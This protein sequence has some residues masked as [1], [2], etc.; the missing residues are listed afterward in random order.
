M[1]DKEGNLSII[2]L[3]TLKYFPSSDTETE[4]LNLF[5]P[6]EDLYDNLDSPRIIRSSPRNSGKSCLIT[7]TPKSNSKLGNNDTNNLE[8]LFLEESALSTNEN[9]EKEESSDSENEYELENDSIDFEKEDTV[10]QILRPSIEDLVLQ[11]EQ[12]NIVCHGK[13][14]IVLIK[15]LGELTLIEDYTEIK[16]KIKDHPHE[17]M[18]WDTYRDIMSKLEVKLKNTE[19]NLKIQIEEIQ[20][21]KLKKIMSAQI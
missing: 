2:R 5:A 14:A 20:S 21:R 8:A 4:N 11:D 9:L 17:E 19:D 18:Y 1:E 16:K 7:S 13:N 12:K 6:V 3:K 15:V 10:V